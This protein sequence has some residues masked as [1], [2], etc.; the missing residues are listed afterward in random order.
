MAV[1]RSIDSPRRLSKGGVATA[2][3]VASAR[4]RAT[5]RWR[6]ADGVIRLDRSG[7]SARRLEAQQAACDRRRAFDGACVDLEDELLVARARPI[8]STRS[9]R[10]AR[11]GE[12][13]E[14]LADELLRLDRHLHLF[15]GGVEPL[16]HDGAAALELD[17]G[18]APVKH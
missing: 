2:M 6:R 17:H 18:R 8:D 13:V 11:L 4:T 15:A 3:P 5:A 16:D 14:L 1:S 10:L 12:V 9:Q 7:R